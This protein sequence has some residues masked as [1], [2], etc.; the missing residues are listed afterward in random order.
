MDEDLENKI[1]NDIFTSCSNLYNRSLPSPEEKWRI[2]QKHHEKIYYQT[3][4]VFQN[5]LQEQLRKKDIEIQRLHKELESYRKEHR[6]PVAPCKRDAAVSATRIRSD[7][8]VSSFNTWAINPQLKLPSAF[9][10]V[11]ENPK[12]KTSQSLSETSKPTKWIVNRDG[13]K[14]YLFPNP[15]FFNR[16]T[17]IS[18][19]YIL[20]VNFLR[21]EGQNRIEI[22][23]PCEMTD[24]GFINFSGELD[25]L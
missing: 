1:W 10:Y 9:Y 18:A 4:E 23:K 25:I 13:T 6:H 7:D 22:T 5:F 16:F 21:A 11:K 3:M 17:D 24:S 19:F 14:K 2:F 15:N 8:I 12:I 20:D